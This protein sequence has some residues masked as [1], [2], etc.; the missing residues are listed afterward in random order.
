MSQTRRY[1]QNYWR[2]RQTYP[3]LVDDFVAEHVLLVLEVLRDRLP[4]VGEV[5]P[6]VVGVVV[7]AL[8]A[9]RHLG[10]EVIREEVA[11]QARVQRRGA[12]LV[13][14][15]RLA[16][17]RRERLHGVGLAGLADLVHVVGHALAAVH[18]VEE[19]LV[20][21]EDHV[22]VVLLQDVGDLLDLSQVREVVLALRRLNTCPKNNNNSN[23]QSVAIP[24]IYT[25]MHR[26]FTPGHMVPSLTRLKPHSF[27]L[28]ASIS[29]S[30]SSA[31]A[32][33]STQR[34]SPKRAISSK[35][36]LIASFASCS[37]VVVPG[38]KPSDCGTQGAICKDNWPQ[39]KAPETQ[40]KR[41]GLQT[42][43][44]RS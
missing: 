3:G 37:I 42:N 25:H 18:A 4:H 21:V 43:K 34:A 24:Q 5:V 31:E 11:L 32:K 44:G 41:S 22:D 1:Q 27:R 26:S 9:V 35:R 36:P 12:G 6:E 7:Q 8:E 38:S 29:D 39:K 16:Q 15:H 17:R 20:H 19:V 2:R 28:A 13:R 40:R 23:E 14:R 30:D 33:T 10:G